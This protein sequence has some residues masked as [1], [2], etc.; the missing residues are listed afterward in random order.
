[1]IFFSVHFVPWV[2]YTASD[3]VLDTCTTCGRLMHDIETED[4]VLEEVAFSN[5]TIV[6]RCERYHHFDGLLI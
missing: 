5:G 4:L 6:S 2:L 3:I 1:M